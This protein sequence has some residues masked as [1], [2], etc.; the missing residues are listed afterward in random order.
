M[1]VDLRIHTL[2]QK[3]IGED[4]ISLYQQHYDLKASIARFY[5]VYG[6]HH[7]KEGAY[8]TVIGKWEKAIETDNPMLIYG[9]W[10][11]T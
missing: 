11:K 9:R 1:L 10:Y 5:N 7:L 4:I 6:P 8:C 3:D 2:S